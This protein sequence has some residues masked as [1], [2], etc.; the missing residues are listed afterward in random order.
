[1][2]AHLP[3]RQYISVDALEGILKEK[4][5]ALVTKIYSEWRENFVRG[6][7]SGEKTGGQHVPVTILKGENNMPEAVGCTLS[8]LMRVDQLEI[9]TVKIFEATQQHITF[10]PRPPYSEILSSY[11][12]AV[13][14]AG[15][16]I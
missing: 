2:H 8:I 4:V 13:T 9:G 16:S 1:M 12:V 11:L 7:I 14:K 3:L 15:A 5:D 10:T 6:G